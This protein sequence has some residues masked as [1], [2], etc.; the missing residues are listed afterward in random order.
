MRYIC[1]SQAHTHSYLFGQKTAVWVSATRSGLNQCAVVLIDFEEKKVESLFQTALC[2]QI[3]CWK[4]IVFTHDF[5][6]PT[7]VAF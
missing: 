6:Q 2:S 1:E 3:G 4:K 5:L 7:P